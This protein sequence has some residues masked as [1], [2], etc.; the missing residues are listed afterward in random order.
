MMPNPKM[1]ACPNWLPLKTDIWSI[2]S[3]PV[4]PLP[5]NW[6]RNFAWSNTGS[7]I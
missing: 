1:V 5:S 7:G 2:R 6:L 4:P 3:L